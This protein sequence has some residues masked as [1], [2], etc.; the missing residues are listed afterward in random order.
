M[1]PHTP[2]LSLGLS[3]RLLLSTSISFFL[4]VV[5]LRR[6][7][8]EQ[9]SQVAAVPLNAFVPVRKTF[10]FLWADAALCQGA[11]LDFRPPTRPLTRPYCWTQPSQPSGHSWVRA[12]ISGI[13]SCYTGE[14][15]PLVSKVS[16]PPPTT[17]K[18]EPTS[19]DLHSDFQSPGSFL[20]ELSKESDGP[21][22]PTSAHSDLCPLGVLPSSA[23]L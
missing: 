10:P 6:Q 23:P 21:P 4:S 13:G 7:M 19:P 8:L 14:L 15:E 12:R 11:Q 22:P 2:S 16:W 1:S 20:F 18:L 17:L 3:P 9:F 5:Q